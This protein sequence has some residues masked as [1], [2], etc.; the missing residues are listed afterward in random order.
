MNKDLSDKEIENFSNLT[1]KVSCM[2]GK[3]GVLEHGIYSIK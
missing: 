1:N 3:H 2:S